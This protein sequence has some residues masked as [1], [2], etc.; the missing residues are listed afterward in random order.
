MERPRRGFSRQGVSHNL[1]YRTF[2]PNDNIPQ[3]SPPSTNPRSCFSPFLPPPHC[4]SQT[5]NSTLL[6]HTRSPTA[7]LYPPRT[8]LPSTRCFRERTIIIRTNPQLR[9]LF[10]RISFLLRHDFPLPIQQDLWTPYVSFHHIKTSRPVNQI[11]LGRRRGG[12]SSGP[13]CVLVAHAAIRPAEV[14][15]GNIHAAWKAS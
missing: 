3:L 1:Y 2:L 13:P 15:P 12:R 11:P 5:R 8:T 9:P 6:T 7:W 14:S 4:A 10:P